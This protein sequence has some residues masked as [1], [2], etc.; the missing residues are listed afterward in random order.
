MLK[1]IF[2]IFTAISSHVI[3]RADAA[4]LPFPPE[5][6]FPSMS[7]KDKQVEQQKLDKLLKDTPYCIEPQEA[8]A[9]YDHIL[10]SPNPDIDDLQG[11]ASNYVLAGKMQK[12]WQIRIKIVEHEQATL[13]DWEDLLLS[14]TFFSERR[15]HSPNQKYCD[16]IEKAC[17]KLEKESELSTKTTKGFVIKKTILQAR[18]WLNSLPKTDFS[19]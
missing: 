8:T 2:P 3:Y 10:Q 12:A 14:F 19:S 1:I 17:K 11:A 4:D 13:E 16:I 6:F 15:P 18:S 5:E 7:H 9:I